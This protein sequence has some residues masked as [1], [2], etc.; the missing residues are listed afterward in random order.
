MS[1]YNEHGKET[2]KGRW[3]THQIGRR[4]VCRVDGLTCPLNGNGQIALLGQAKSV[5][6]SSKLSVVV[7][8]FTP[9][10]HY[11]SV[12]ALHA[13]TEVLFE[14]GGECLGLGKAW[15]RMAKRMRG[16]RNRKGSI[17][18]LKRR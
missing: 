13:S 15:I 18:K 3:A 8:L 6:D 12:D 4:E 5:E 16:R 1:V 2:C 10:F 7:R 17:G 11:S 14:L 9:S